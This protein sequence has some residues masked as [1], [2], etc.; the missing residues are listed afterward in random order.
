[1]WMRCEIPILSDEEPSSLQR[2]APL[3]DCGN[4]ISYNGRL[5]SV[6][7]TNIDLTLSVHRQPVGDWFASRS[8]S[9]WQPNGIGLADSE[10]F[11]VHGPVGRATQN[12]ILNSGGQSAQLLEGTEFT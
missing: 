3:A 1:M 10:L 12:L 6:S 5:G 8:V 2:I 9:H 11:D 4:G 7:F